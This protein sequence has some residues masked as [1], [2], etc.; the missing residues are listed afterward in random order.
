MLA[1]RNKLTLPNPVTQAGTFLID[2]GAQICRTSN[3]S[4]TRVLS[5]VEDKVVQDITGEEGT[6]VWSNEEAVIHHIPAPTLN[7]AH[8]LRL[9]S[10]DRDQ[11]IRAK[12]IM[13]ADFSPQSLGLS[14][15]EKNR[16]LEDLHT[17]TYTAC[18][19]SY[20]QGMNVIEQ[21][22]RANKWNVDY[23]AVVQIW[24]AGCI[25][26]ADHIA[27]ML[28]PIVAKHTQEDSLNLLFQPSVGK[29]L[30]QGLPCLR[31]VVAKAVGADHVVP[32]L[33]A[34]LEYIK[35]QTNT[36][37]SLVGAADGSLSR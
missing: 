12:K 35:Y 6:G 10:A 21:A 29:E 30:K 4:G 22:D 16:L 2:I 34:S 18:L 13:D 3:K 24:R 14:G 8:D 37:T 31:R 23:S 27:D 15:E 9:A 20:V 26:Q 25:I 36:G 32:A 1:G 5:T 19:A 17:A 28:E 7:I 11:R 33:S